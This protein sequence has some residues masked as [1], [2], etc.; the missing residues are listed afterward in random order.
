MTGLG[1]APSRA[2]A[3]GVLFIGSACT[4]AVVGPSAPVDGAVRTPTDARAVG[5]E[6]DGG[7]LGA[8]V[9]GGA[10]GA[11]VDGG[12]LPPPPT[13][14]T[15][16]DYDRFLDQFYPDR[17]YSSNDIAMRDRTIGQGQS[18]WDVMSNDMIGQGELT[19]TRFRARFD[20]YLV[21]TRV[22][23]IGAAGGYGDG[24]GGVIRMRIYP[25]VDG[26]PDTTGT[27]HGE[28][29]FRPALSPDHLITADGGGDF[30]DHE[31]S[32][33][34]PLVA[35]ERY[36]IV[37]EN[38]DPNPSE[39]FIS[40]ES[41]NTRA[42]NVPTDPLFD[43]TDWVTLRKA[44]ADDWWAFDDDYAFLQ[45]MQQITQAGGAYGFGM[46][47]PGNYYDSNF[48]FTR[49]APIR[50]LIRPRATRTWYGGAIAI[51]AITG[52]F[53]DW[54][55]TTEAGATLAAGSF[56]QAS[57]DDAPT[58]QEASSMRFVSWFP[59]WFG[60]GVELTGG[61]SYFLTYTPRDASSWRSTTNGDGRPSDRFPLLAWPEVS[62]QHWYDGEFLFSHQYSHSTSDDVGNWRE[63][64]VTSE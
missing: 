39:N 11:P 37:F 10:L 35:G 24:T 48:V 52:G 57:P 4:G 28:A 25:D 46:Y 22:Y 30:H 5:A 38:I 40:R 1:S 21:S 54:E 27:L 15:T 41:A 56:E 63:Y 14:T 59:F 20:G 29:T 64:F 3:L 47:A 26:L 17:P 13:S 7:A 60:T 42:D 49:A 51:N 61:E 45:P 36:H 55:L 6:A 44:G 9:D 23:W 16:A 43:R 32:Q 18:P 2:L 58:A 53:I 50:T 8:P 12:T 19:A 62:A 34:V 33:L 31:F